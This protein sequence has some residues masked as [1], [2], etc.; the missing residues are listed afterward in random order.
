MELKVDRVTVRFGALMA[1]S[2]VSFSVQLGEI[3]A[4]IGPNG[5]GKTTLLNAISGLVEPAGGAVAIGGVDVTGRPPHERTRCG[6][7]RTFQHARLMNELPVIENVLTGGYTG[8]RR[9]DLFAEWIRVPSALRRLRAQ[10]AQ[11]LALLESMD[12]GDV[13]ELEVSQLSFGRKKLVDLAR[14]LMAKPRL[15]LMD[16]P[17]A[18][19]SETEISRLV[20]VVER[21]RATTAIVLVAHHMGFVSKVANQVICLVA[22]RVISRGSPREVQSDPQVLA[23]YMGSA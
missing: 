23:A 8:L 11:A 20:S 15:V 14:A 19:L 2:E 9:L 6:M 22:G 21:V 7:G 10:R 13:A 3:L 17:T 5:A 16:E 12:L 1:L 18:G 4:L